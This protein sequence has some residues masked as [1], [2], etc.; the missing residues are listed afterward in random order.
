MKSVKTGFFFLGVCGLHVLFSRYF[1]THSYFAFI[2]KTYGFLFLLYLGALGTKAFLKKRQ[3][4]S[5]YLVL[6]T[7]LI[8]IILSVIYLLPIIN[9]R[10][11][12]TSIYIGHFFISYFIFL[13]KE[14]IEYKHQLK[15]KNNL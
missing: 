9:T 4:K 2:A 11:E 12:L 14:I 3:L 10:T 1:T 5:P 13:A 8:K 15:T 7:N 6:S